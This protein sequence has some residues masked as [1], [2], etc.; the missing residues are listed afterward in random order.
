MRRY[1]RNKYATMW[2]WVRGIWIAASLVMALRAGCDWRQEQ[3]WQENCLPELQLAMQSASPI[4]TAI[5]K[6]ESENHEPPRDLSELTPR[7][8]ARLPAAGPLAR[9][10]WIYPRSKDEPSLGGWAL[11]IRVRH[12]FCRRHFF[13]FGDWFV[14]HPFGNYPR[15]A[16]GGVLEQVKGRGN[17]DWGY[18]HE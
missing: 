15:E 7:Y 11:A 8:L 14:Y 13:D 9:D 4:I 10:G 2:Q 6:Y 17:G 12:G 1:S 16:Y 18:Y 3:L 5:Q